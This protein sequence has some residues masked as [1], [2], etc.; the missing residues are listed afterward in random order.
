MNVYVRVIVEEAQRRGI[1]VTVLDAD[2]G[3]LHLSHGARDIVAFDALTELTSAVALLRCADKE[4]SRA[5]LADAGLRVPRGRMASF[6]DGD[7]AFLAEVGALVV[8]PAHGEQGNGVTVGVHDRAQLDEAVEQARRL[9][10]QVLLE[11]HVQGEDL[12]VMVIGHAVVGAAVRRRPEVTGTGK[13]SI[14]ELIDEQSRRRADATGGE[15]TIPIDED[16][17]EAVA[18]AGYA[19]DDVLAEGQTVQVRGTANL[20][21]GGTMH[22]VTQLLH[23]DLAESCARAS[24]ALRIPVVGLDLIAPSVEEAEHVFIEANERPGLAFHEPAPVVPRFIDLLFP[25]TAAR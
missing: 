4:L 24:R 23:P 6:D 3:H 16:T 14:E 15:S 20:H 12:R 25:D 7:G 21:T 17:R 22:D 2:K 18:A 13:H 19:L 8:K 11:E 9:S 10:E 1:A 5:V